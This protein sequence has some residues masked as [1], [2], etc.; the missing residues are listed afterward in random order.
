MNKLCWIFLLALLFPKTSWAYLDPSTI[1]VFLAGVIGFISAML[2]YAK[3]IIQ[4]IKKFF[5]SL[6]KKK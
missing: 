6:R 5:T 3:S 4:K 1:Q 2:I